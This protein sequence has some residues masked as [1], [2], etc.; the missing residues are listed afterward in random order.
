MHAMIYTQSLTLKAEP[1]PVA[2]NRHGYVAETTH[3][4]TLPNPVALTWNRCGCGGIGRG[5]KNGIVLDV[6]TNGL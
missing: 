2:S 6:N 5:G 4:Q 1:M 3:A